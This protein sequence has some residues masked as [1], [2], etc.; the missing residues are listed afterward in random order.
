LLVGVMAI[1]LTNNLS[2]Y[3]VGACVF[4][5]GWAAAFAYLFAIIADVDAD[6]KHIALSAPAVGVGSMIGPGMAGFL[7]SEG[8]TA[9]LQIMCVGTVAAS[10]APACLSRK[11][12]RLELSPAVRPTA[13]LPVPPIYSLVFNF[14]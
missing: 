9:P 4:M 13:L 6:S 8:S 14:I 7:L 3:A 1:A 2:D 10:V 12:Q 11:K 5:F